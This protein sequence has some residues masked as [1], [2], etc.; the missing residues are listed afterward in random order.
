VVAADGASA[1][2]S[3]HPPAKATASTANANPNPVEERSVI[4]VGISSRR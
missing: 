3:L 4:T 1:V 2:F